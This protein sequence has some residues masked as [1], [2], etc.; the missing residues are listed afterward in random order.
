MTRV[1]VVDD[2]VL[3]RVGVASCIDWEAHGF[4]IVGQAANGRE[5]LAI[6]EREGADIVL[7]DIIMP[8]MDGLQLIAELRERLPAARIVVLSCHDELEYVKQAMKLGAVD[9]VLK[10]SLHPEQL[11]K[12]LEEARAGLEAEAVAEPRPEAAAAA[13]ELQAGLSMTLETSSF[14][15]GV[16]AALAGFAVRGTAAAAFRLPRGGDSPRV[17]SSCLSLAESTSRPSRR[18]VGIRI[19]PETVALAVLLD[20]CGE[21]AHRKLRRLC[22]ELRERMSGLFD[23][24]SVWACAGPS[25]G[26]S[27]VAGVI[28]EALRRL[29]HAFFLPPGSIGEAV[30]SPALAPVRLSDFEEA[31]LRECLEAGNAADYE[32]VVSAVIKR[33]ARPE[34][35]TP[36]AVRA[37]LA[38]VHLR[39]RGDAEAPPSPTILGAPAL[40]IIERELK[41]LPALHAGQASART[42]RMRPEIAR[43]R[44]FVRANLSRRLSVREAAELACM[45]P[46]H[47]CTTFRRETSESFVHFS[48]RVRIEWARHLMEEEGFLVRQAAEAVGMGDI[49]YFSKLFKRI[50]GRSPRDARRAGVSENE[51]PK[52]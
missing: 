52:S 23:T 4:T 2:E 46:N 36:D 45:S 42:A 35:H 41:A 27:A 37:C 9:Y 6:A 10:L 34:A 13:A 50:I 25:N 20:E 18:L 17:A 14:V 39:L 40:Y 21:D 48:N 51:P 3:V 29:D 43:V 5:A 12:V 33:I 24:E 11:L 16:S 31:S 28:L 49:P 7:T 30:F 47:F 19:G 44:E 8:E 15:R 26:T 38:E 1:L 22:D 32:R